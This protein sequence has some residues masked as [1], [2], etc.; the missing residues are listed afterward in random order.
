MNEI[1]AKSK[2][3]HRIAVVKEIAGT[4]FDRKIVE[5]LEIAIQALK[6]IREYR[7]MEERLNGISVKQVVDG[8]IKQVENETQEEYKQGRILTNKEAEDWNEYQAIGSVEELKAFRSDDF[9]QDLLNMGYTKGLKDGYAKAID[10]FA[11]R[12]KELIYKWIEKGV[13][14]IGCIDEI[15]EQMK[16]G[17]TDEG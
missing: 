17:A 15:A 6:E 9:T 13:I 16:G 11:E 14:A 8:F 7:A 3:K 12:M 5:D 10:E 2:I 4:R 1:E